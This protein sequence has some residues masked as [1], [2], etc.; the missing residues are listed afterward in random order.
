VRLELQVPERVAAGE[1]F[2]VRVI[3]VNDAFEPVEIWRNALVG[4]TATPRGGGLVPESVEPSYGQEESA[5]LLQPFS[6]YGRERDAGGFDAGVV[7]VTA[8][9][10]PDDG[11]PLSATRTVA[12]G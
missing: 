9:Y 6:F 11:E 5:V 1:S 7:D 4:P 3:L 12:V 10:R 2:P 8:T